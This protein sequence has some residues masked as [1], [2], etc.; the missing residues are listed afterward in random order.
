MSILQ[1]K[2]DAINR[3]VDEQNSLVGAYNSSIDKTYKE[4]LGNEISAYDKAIQS[5]QE[6]LKNT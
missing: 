3:L 2:Q 4:G 5:A 6:D 1:A